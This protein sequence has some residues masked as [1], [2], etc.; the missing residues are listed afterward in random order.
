GVCRVSAREFG[1]VDPA[2]GSPDPLLDLTC[3]H[4]MRYPDLPAPRGLRLV[5][6]VATGYPRVSN[7]GKTYTF[8][9][10]RGFR[11]SNKEPVRPLAFAGAIAR[12]LALGGNDVVIDIAVAEDVPRGTALMPAGVK[13]R[14]DRLIIRLKGAIPD[15]PA[16]TTI[17]IFC[18]V[19]P[20][21]PADPEGVTA[22]PGSG[23]Y[24]VASSIPGR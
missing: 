9:L 2:F 13:T 5:A 1:P 4:L 8:T 6:E 16:R 24:Y 22:L 7:A 19:P 20:N 12:V 21:L 18:A 15:F 14:G 23:P 11:F 10:R 3:A 17:P